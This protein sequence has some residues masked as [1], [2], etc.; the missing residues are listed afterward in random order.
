VLGTFVAELAGT[1]WDGTS[2]GV[3]K[4]NEVPPY[5]FFSK[6]ASVSTPDPMFSV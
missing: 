1:V 3:K 5:A 2:K 6:E 4:A